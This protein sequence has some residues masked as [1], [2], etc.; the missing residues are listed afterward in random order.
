ML[1]Y[2]PNIAKSPNLTISIKAITQGPRVNWIRHARWVNDGNIWTSS[3]VSAGIDMMYAY[4]TE[5]YGENVAAYI[6]KDMEYVRNTD[7]SND[8]FAGDGA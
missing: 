4:V 5:L 6:A 2:I 3:G 8:P 7:A 1:L